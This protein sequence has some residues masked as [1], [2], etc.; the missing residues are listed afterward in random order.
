MEI[1]KI[2]DIQA[3]LDKFTHILAYS[4][5][6]QTFSGT[7]RIFCNR[8]IFRTLEYSEPEAYSEAKEYWERYQST[9]VPFAKIVNGY[10]YVRKP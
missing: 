2:K 8:Q 1:C 5:I 3:D 9:M 7:F 4:G 6:I 10:D